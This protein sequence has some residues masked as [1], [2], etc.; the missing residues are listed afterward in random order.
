MTRSLEEFQLRSRVTPEL[1]WAQIRSSVTRL[2]RWSSSS[3]RVTLI[4]LS[5]APQVY[6]SSSHPQRAHIV[7]QRYCV[8]AKA[9]GIPSPWPRVEPGHKWR[10]GDRIWDDGAHWKGD[11]SPVPD[12]DDTEYKV[13]QRFF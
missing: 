4:T 12:V 10:E 13:C 1:I 3:E 9:R 6:H 7:S 5:C 8:V 11:V 2:L